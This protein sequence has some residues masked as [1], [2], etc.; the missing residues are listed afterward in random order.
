[1]KIKILILDDDRQLA[2]EMSK[3]LIHQNYEVV[4][5]HTIK[6]AKRQIETFHPDIALLDLKLP[7]GSGLDFLRTIR[8]QIPEA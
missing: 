3:F 7:D 4:T 2:E 8:E 6:D 5:T 1:M